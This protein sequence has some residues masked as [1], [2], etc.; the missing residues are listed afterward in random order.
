MTTSKY[1]IQTALDT[2]VNMGWA[3]VCYNQ[4]RNNNWEFIHTL[5]EKTSLHSLK[6]AAHHLKLKTNK[7]IMV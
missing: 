5:T 4:Q 3:M 1:R 6:W 2:V 7:N